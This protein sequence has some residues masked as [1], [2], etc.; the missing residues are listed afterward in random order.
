MY[1]SLA[2]KDIDSAVDMDYEEEQ[3]TPEDEPTDDID[4]SEFM[5][6]LENHE[7]ENMNDVED[8]DMDDVEEH[9]DE[10][11]GEIEEHDTAE[12][13]LPDV[14]EQLANVANELHPDAPAK[15]VL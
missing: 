11:M 1:A 8:D 6:D 12:E 5:G 2:D 7:D 15:Q 3:H 13:D 10:H 14:A 9:D 4:E